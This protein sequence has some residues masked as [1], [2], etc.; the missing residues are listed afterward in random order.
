MPNNSELRSNKPVKISVVIPVGD[1]KLYKD[2]ILN[3][4][5][6]AESINAETILVFDGALPSE[7]NKIEEFIE[8]KHKD[9]IIVSVSCHNPGG[10]R[11]AGKVLATG[12]WITFWDCD[13]IP[14]ALEIHSLIQEAND[15]NHDVSVGRFEAVYLDDDLNEVYRKESRKLLRSNWEFIVGLTPGIWRFGFRT[16]LAKTIDFAE[17]RMGEDQVFIARLLSK[18][19]QVYLSNKVTY[20][21]FVG[22]G[23]QLTSNVTAIHD[24]VFAVDLL[25][26]EFV[27]K[28]DDFRDLKFTMLI[29]MH[30]SIFKLRKFPIVLRITN[31]LQA[32]KLVFLHQPQFF[33]LVVVTFK[34][35]VKSSY[36]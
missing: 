29:K 19:I 34:E 32:L 22:R 12:D 35:K 26:Q 24:K 4:I 17:L 25:I 14:N 27:K 7:I 33:R 5:V 30:L 8:I 6:A 10:A 23:S 3:L 9:V 1:L 15:L 21:Y 2:N 31:L 20:S 28:N 16:S 13:D 11:N 36:V 18:K